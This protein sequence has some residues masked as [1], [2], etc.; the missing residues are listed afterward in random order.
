VYGNNNP[1]T[2]PGDAG[3]YCSYGDWKRD[4]GRIFEDIGRMRRELESQPD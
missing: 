4:K 2:E 3:F 1:V